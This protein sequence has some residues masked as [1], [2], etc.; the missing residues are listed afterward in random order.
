V[1][2]LFW[3]VAQVV[4]GIMVCLAIILAVSMALT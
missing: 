4:V 1:S 2:D 3:F